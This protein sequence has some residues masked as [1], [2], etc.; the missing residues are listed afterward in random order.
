[1]VL[2][3]HPNIITTTVEHMLNQGRARSIW[4]FAFS[5]ACCAIEGFMH[6]LASPRFDCDRYGFV[7]R[8][9]PRHSDLMIVGGPITGKMVPVIRRLYEQ[10]AEPKWVLAMGACSSSGGLFKDSYNVVQ[11]VDKIIPVEIYVPGCPPRPEGLWYGLLE[12][13]EKIKKSEKMRYETWQPPVPKSN[14]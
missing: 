6:A 14:S 5:P 4:P 8:G 10:M 3:E 9:T 11:G 12:L 7:P 13:R 1:M 2:D